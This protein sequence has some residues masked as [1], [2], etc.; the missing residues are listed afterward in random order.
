MYPKFVFRLMVGLFILSFLYLPL[1]SQSIVTGAIEGKV[2]SDTGEALP[3]VKIVLS[4]DILIQREI[5]TLTNERGIYRFPALQPGTYSIRATLE[6]FAPIEQRAVRVT[7]GKT[8]KANLTLQVGTL[9]EEIEVIAQAPLI[10]VKDSATAVTDLPEELLTNIPNRQN[11]QSI[12]NLAPGVVSDSAYGAPIQTGISYQIDGVNVS[13]PGEG[14]KWVRLDY[15]AV[16]EVSVSGIG[17]PAEYGEYSGVIFNTVTKSG[18]NRFEGYVELLFQGRGWTSSHEAAE[19]A[20]IT[21]QERQEIGASFNLSGPII[22]DKLTFFISGA[23]NNSRAY[24]AEFKDWGTVYPETYSNWY[25]PKIFAKLSWQ[26][27]GNTRIHL[28]TQYDDQR[29]PASMGG[30][31]VRD[32]ANAEVEAPNFILNGDLIHSFSDKTF[33]EA[34]FAYYN[35]K[36]QVTP[37]KGR[38]PGI[39]DVWNWVYYGNH[40][41]RPHDKK[42]RLQIK[43]SV[44]HHA[45]DFLGTHDLK[46]GVEHQR[47][48]FLYGDDTVAYY[49]YYFGYPGYEYTVVGSWGYEHEGYVRTTGVFV[50]DNWSVTDRLTINPGLRYTFYSGKVETSTEK[51]KTKPTW[52]PRIGLTYDFLGDGSLALK[53][54]WGRYYDNLYIR[55]FKTLSKDNFASFG[56]YIFDMDLWQSTFDYNNPD[57]ADADPDSYSLW[58]YDPGGGT[59]VTVD[60][61]LKQ[62]FMDQWTVGLEYE[63]F[64]DTSIGITY[65]DRHHKDLQGQIPVGAVWSPEVIENPLGGTITAY[66]R[67]AIENEWLI[68]NPSASRHENIL[69]EPYRKYKGLEFFLNKRFSDNW[70]LMLSYVYGNATGSVDNNST[71]LAAG[72]EV[73][74]GWAKFYHSPNTQINSDGHLTFDPTHMFKAQGTVVLPFDINF[75]ANFSII[76]GNRWTRTIKPDRRKYS[77]P[78]AANLN[79]FLEERG[80]QRYPAKYN[81]DLRLEKT[82]IFDRF[83]FGIYADAFNVF[84][85][86]AVTSWLTWYD[87]PVYQ[88]PT[89]IRAPRDFKIGLR[90]W[91]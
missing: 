66:T 67:D 55:G 47:G 44:S 53:A 61:D 60:P 48:H 11:W 71:R 34:K 25:T 14:A 6:G 13:D 22:K 5:E 83:R 30:W 76:S 8:L 39:V 10:D 62:P 91:F 38:E 21:Y 37:V 26:A 18:T 65:I 20:G 82:F 70:M 41:Y 16:E 28:F 79:I 52:A 31:G 15:N 88:K 73:N 86:D 42:E 56:A 90:F 81:L 58:W 75:S 72:A 40:I 35:G 3:N 17:A 24:Y 59:N 84:N 89:G 80:A 77:M 64:R 1:S 12:V 50:Q 9:A 32:G 68:T 19:A 85:D 63:L 7:L 74:S 27:S 78:S 23:W 29:S 54:H 2:V 43:T 36:W 87:L 4:S 46:A 57:I 33:L 45:D 49:T 69:V 51:V